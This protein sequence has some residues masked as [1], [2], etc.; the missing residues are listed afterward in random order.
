MPNIEIWGLGDV[1]IRVMT[2]SAARVRSQIF[3]IVLKA[4]ADISGPNEEDVVVTV[5]GSTTFDT[6][7]HSKPFLR[8]IGTDAAELEVLSNWLEPIGMDIEIFP[9]IIFK[10]KK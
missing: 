1:N 4:C 10:P 6:E 3:E 5:V 8:L 9:P 2:Q 7:G